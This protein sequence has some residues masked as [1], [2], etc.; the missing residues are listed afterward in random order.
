MTTPGYTSTLFLAR[1][2]YVYRIPPRSSLGGYRASDWADKSTGDLASTAIWKGRLRVVESEEE[3]ETEGGIRKG[4]CE[5]RLEDSETGE[6]FALCPYDVTA[7]SVEAVLD[8][9]RY[10]VLRV[11]SEGPNGGAKRKAFI[12]MGVSMDTS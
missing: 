11:E 6:T 4:R 1:L 3:P 10:F 7:S 5:I 9:S 2:C 8:S 12:G